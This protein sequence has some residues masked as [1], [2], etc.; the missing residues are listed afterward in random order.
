MERDRALSCFAE[1][2][3]KLP[4][5]CGRTVEGLMVGSGEE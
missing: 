2:D 4:L 1:R 3:V 5:L